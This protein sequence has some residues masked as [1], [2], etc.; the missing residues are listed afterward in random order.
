MTIGSGSAP[1]GPTRAA[2]AAASCLAAR[3][4]GFFWSASATSAAT[5][6]LASSGVA[7]SAAGATRAARVKRRIS[8]PAIRREL[9]AGPRGPGG[10]EHDV[11]SS[12]AISPEPPE[13]GGRGS[14]RR[15]VSSGERRRGGRAGRR[16]R[17]AEPRASERADATSG[18]G[19]SAVGAS[20]RTRG[21]AAAS[22]TAGD[23]VTGFSVQP[24]GGKASSPSLSIPPQHA[25]GGPAEQ[26][27]A[28]SSLSDGP[29]ASAAA[30][31]R[32][33][34][35]DDAT[36]LHRLSGYGGRVGCQ[37]IQLLRRPPPLNSP[38]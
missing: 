33:T 17:A 3:T 26:G 29:V 13:T 31:T 23:G 18:A 11:T 34:S 19:A 22:T 25:I 35:P 16:G 9:G 37:A 15:G 36:V 24:H 28:A 27:E 10:S 8:A 7:G 14:G 4:S 32:R 38:Q 12:N 5:S 1:A 30:T 21:G 20:A 6:A 2:A